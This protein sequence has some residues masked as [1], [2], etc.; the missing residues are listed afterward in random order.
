MDGDWRN[1]EATAATIRDGWLWTGD[2]GV[3][4]ATGFLTLKD[5]SK[6]LV[7]SGG[8]NI[9]PLEVEEVLL[10]PP[11]VSVLARDGP[12]APEW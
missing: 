5:R 1:A 3:L 12:P 10:P 7:I 11:P 8:P 9:Y 2:M 6:D 4:D